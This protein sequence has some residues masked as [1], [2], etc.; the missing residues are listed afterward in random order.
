MFSRGVLVRD[1]RLLL[2]IYMTQGG[3]WRDAISSVPLD[4][5]FG[6]SWW[7]R[8]NKLARASRL[9]VW[10]RSWV[11]QLTAAGSSA[12]AVASTLLQLVFMLITSFHYLTC[13]YWVFATASRGSDPLW[14][15]DTFSAPPNLDDEGLLVQYMY[16][17]YRVSHPGGLLRGT[18]PPTGEAALFCFAITIYGLFLFAYVIGA[19]GTVIADTDV[20]SARFR[21][22]KMAVERFLNM[23]RVPSSDRDL[24]SHWFRVEWQN[25]N[26][27]SVSSV[28]AGLPKSLTRRLRYELCGGNLR[29]AAIFATLDDKSLVLLAE[30]L[31]IE[32]LA[33]GQVLFH[34]GELGT[35]MFVVVGGAVSLYFDE[36]GGRLVT[37]LVDAIA[38]A[39]DGTPREKSPPKRVAKRM[40][41]RSGSK[42]L[43]QHASE[44]LDIDDMRDPFSTVGPGDV[45][46]EFAYFEGVRLTTAIAACATELYIINYD[47]LHNILKRRPFLESRMRLLARKKLFEMSA[48]VNFILQRNH[49]PAGARRTSSRASR[50]RSQSGHE[51]AASAWWSPKRT[52]SSVT[53]AERSTVGT[54]TPSGRERVVQDQSAPIDTQ[55]G[56]R[57]RMSLAS[58]MP[59]HAQTS[60]PRAAHTE[61]SDS[62]SEGKP[63]GGD[64][65]VGSTEAL[66]GVDEP[67]PHKKL[68]RIPLFA[69]SGSLAAD[70][71]ADADADSTAANGAGS[72]G[73]MMLA[74]LSE[75]RFRDG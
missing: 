42:S 19:L 67:D 3:F 21:E 41:S 33:D 68:W 36:Y 22:R 54:R 29:R 60:D 10:I 20:A 56:P 7:T 71:D 66:N 32:M 64:A 65:Y 17:A 69:A 15:D 70:T 55:V 24:V 16:A 5:I 11:L 26:G 37:D 9:L 35:D 39:K 61:M 4:W 74:P 53:P 18:T 31:Q 38:R 23:R 63:G 40:Q 72:S 52:M 75:G 45:G 51:D 6:A 8:I 44:W 62:G 48:I 58:R 73:G 49:I 47:M 13:L 27:L 50:F 57:D 43:R 12:H 30:V 34:A 46:G 2:R 59:A 28:C 1:P 25:N 14:P